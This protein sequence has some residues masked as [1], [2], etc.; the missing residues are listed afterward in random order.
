MP[1]SRC[2]SVARR[3]AMLLTIV[4]CVGLIASTLPVEAG[5]F[6]M[7][8][9]TS[10]EVRIPK[11]S[12]QWSPPRHG[13]DIHEAPQ[14]YQF[15]LREIERR[16]EAT[17]T[18]DAKVTRLGK[19]KLPT[20]LHEAPHEWTWEGYVIRRRAEEIQLLW[21]RTISSIGHDVL[22][23]GMMSRLSRTI[24]LLRVSADGPA[25]AI[26]SREDDIYAVTWE[27]GDYRVGEIRGLDRF[28]LAVRDLTE[29]LTPAETRYHNVFVQK[30]A[31]ARLTGLG[32][33]LDGW[34]V[35]HGFHDAFPISE[36][37]H[38]YAASAEAA[39]TIAKIGGMAL[40]KRRYAVSLIGDAMSV[41]GVADLVAARSWIA[42]R[43]VPQDLDQ[44]AKLLRKRRGSLILVV[45]HLE[46]GKVKIGGSM[47]ERS[48]L[49]RIATEHDVLLMVLGCNS[50]GGGAGVL[51]QV[52]H[53]PLIERVAR[54]FSVSTVNEF[55]AMLATERNPLF[56]DAVHADK[57]TRLVGS[58]EPTR[59]PPRRQ[60]GRLGVY[61]P[62]IMITLTH[63]GRP[64]RARGLVVIDTD[65]LI[66][67][68]PPAPP[69][70]MTPDVVIYPAPIPGDA[71]DRSRSAYESG[72]C[73]GRE[74]GE[75]GAALALLVLFSWPLVDLI[76]SLD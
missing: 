12:H 44:F 61:E 55:H 42:G 76:R 69:T 32:V 24:S 40:P 29:L 62:G 10:P 35:F 49:D 7:P 64:L 3:Q 66:E 59:E 28:P 46:D 26:L 20:I 14:S 50:A 6:R 43:A 53:R 38:V 5:P 39:E 8:R 48:T 15:H 34:R 23:E 22:D 21:S 36:H 27:Y 72:G 41:P 4:S 33:S 9:K 17:T 2:V 11:P 30:E 65:T 1:T 47:V 16:D 54:A 37:A 58:S 74:F 56:L 63:V 18:F 31:L 70:M 75:I 19:S 51:G 67:R 68:D 60:N 52:Q 73:T 71:P 57:L 25:I 13:A 45:S